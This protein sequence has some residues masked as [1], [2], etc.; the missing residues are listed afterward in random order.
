MNGRLRAG[1][2]KL[3]AYL[4]LTTVIFFSGT[5]AGEELSLDS[6][7]VYAAPL[8]VDAEATNG[9]VRVYLSSLGNPSTLNLRV[10]GNY[11]VNGTFL[12]SGTQLTVQFNASTGAI[13][14]SYN[15]QRWDMGKS[16]S[17]RRHSASGIN[18]ILISQ[19]KES[20][21]PYPG[22]LSF[23]AVASGS[24]YTLY[25][26]AHIYIENYLYGVVPYE[27]GN[28][29]NIEALKAQAV[30]ARTYT[31]R[32]MQQRAGGLYDVKDT[33][34][35]QVYRGTPSGNAN[36][37][38]A[39]DATK[40]IVLMYGSQYITTYYSASNGGQT[41]TSRSGSSYAYMKVKDDPFDYANP[42]STVKSKTVYADLTRSDNPS[43]LVSLL[44]SKVIAKLNQIGYAANTGNTVLKTLKSVT[45]HTPKYA[46][47]SRLYTKMDFSLTVQTQNASGQTVTVA[48]TVTCDIFDELESM[49]SMGIQSSDNELWSVEKGSGRFVLQARRYGHGMGMSQ[50][51]AM[52]MGKL[53]YNYAQILGFYYDGCKRI[54]H[55]FTNTILSADSSD[56][57]TVIEDPAEME[58]ED[59][60]ACKGTVRLANAGALL[61]VRCE[62]S[63]SS[64][65]IGTVGNGAI[66]DVLSNDGTW[67]MIRF[68]DLCGYVS[69]TALSI[70]GTPSGNETEVSRILG[71]ATVTA[72]DFVNL[73]SE[74]SMNAAV[75]G[76][77]PTGAVLTVFSTNG[78]WAKVQYNALCAYVNTNYISAVSQKYPSGD[79]SSGTDSAK[80]AAE[81]GFAELRN[82]PSTSAQVLA[83]LMNDATVTVL[84]DDG[85]WCEVKYQGLSG[86]VVADLLAYTDEAVPPEED[87]P[88]EETPETEQPGTPEIP[89]AA[90]PDKEEEESHLYAVV[91][92]AYGSL[93][94]RAE[95][96]AGSR[97]LTTIPRNMRIRVIER[98][99]VW[100]LVQYGGYAGYTMNEF[101]TFEGEVQEPSGEESTGTATVVTPSGSLNLRSEP[102]TGSMILDRIP[103]YMRITVLQRGSEW[104]KVSYGGYTGYVMSTFLV[105]DAVEP[106]AEEPSDPLPEEPDE[107][108]KLPQDPPS[109]PDA[110]YA[111]VTT[112]SGSLNLRYAPIAGSAVLARIPRGTVLLVEERLSAWS[113]TSYGGQNGYVS[114]A[115]LTFTD[116]EQQPDT[117]TPA[118]PSDGYKTARVHTASG[119]LN[120]RQAP[121]G[122]QRVLTTIPRGT[123]LAIIEYGPEWCA[124]EYSGY[125]G[126]VMTSFLRF[127]TNEQPAV[128][129]KDE[130]EN[131]AGIFDAVDAWVVTENGSLNLRSA[132][133]RNAE[134]ITAIPRGAK[135]ELLEKGNDWSF[136]SYGQISGYVMSCYLS[137]TKPD[138]PVQKPESGSEEQEIVTSGQMKLDVTLEMP[139]HAMFARNTTSGRIQLWAM[140]EESG[141]SVGSV[142][143]GGEV[144]I[145]LKGEMW[146]LVQSGDVQ[147]Y[148][149]THLLSVME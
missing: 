108:E 98:G 132:P 131:N 90:E 142:E 118:P 91:T 12:S 130:T 82:S 27:M 89:P 17:L 48:Q 110:Q 120:L 133:D 92:T 36:C 23:K 18:G 135:V 51:G 101:L 129:D 37:V 13:T 136:V 10:Q 74:G 46:A 39:V 96:M 64:D 72:N 66:V 102:R 109:A 32:M 117:E 73:R 103:P 116:N 44:K 16:F 24:G 67:S 86:Y 62:K 50:R 122:G 52:Y 41:E 84:S 57:H 58:E 140:C 87:S 97:I 15:G 128:P 59:I 31:V 123:V 124:V 141:H 56:Q 138:S 79:L 2:Q 112:A 8:T 76:T 121:S 85:A 6:V 105:F 119:S 21:N 111:V 28:S 7:K 95:A 80:V 100:S 107:E 40:G 30:A 114:N 1:M 78:S 38:E 29:S 144:E 69:S 127:D 14:L 54:Q 71:F 147:G 61:A 25:T 94:M 34:S 35:D 42:S 70:S 126:Y 99:T 148:C 143:E 5:A 93:N 75:L 20:Q 139:E 63:N 26:I 43:Q 9:M 145:I 55:K 146:C 81:E 83:I 22:D 134:I 53:G 137:P 149:Y 104:C 49:L 45:P 68:G 65:V 33:T 47:P 19:A 88:E 11:S 106:P 113:R 60:N 125:Y 115:Y 4:L 77:A 3:I